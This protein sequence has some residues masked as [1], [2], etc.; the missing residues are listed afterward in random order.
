MVLL[1]GV[2]SSLPDCT[3]DSDGLCTSCDANFYLNDGVCT[4]NCPSHCTESGSTCDCSSSDKTVFDLKFYDIT[5]LQQA[6]VE[7]FFPKMP[8]DSDE[9]QAPSLTK[10]RGFYFRYHSEM[11]CT[12]SCD[13][14]YDL[15]HVLVFWTK[16]YLG[17]SCD[18]IKQKDDFV[19]ARLHTGAMWS[20]ADWHFETKLTKTSDGTFQTGQVQVNQILETWNK[21]AFKTE[22]LKATD[23]GG[24][25]CSGSSCHKYNLV[26]LSSYKD[27]ALQN[28]QSYQDVWARDEVDTTGGNA[29]Y[30]SEGDFQG[31]VYRIILRN[32]RSMSESHP[33]IS[34]CDPGFY[35]DENSQ[36]QDCYCSDKVWCVRGTGCD[37]CYSE[38]CDSCHGFTEPEC[39]SCSDGSL[40]PCS[41]CDYLCDSCQTPP[42]ECDTNL[43][44]STEEINN[45]CLKN[46]PYGFGSPCSFTSGVVLEE[47]F[48]TFSFT[49]FQ[50]GTGPS[51]YFPFNNGE[52]DDVLPMKQRGVYADSS[53]MIRSIDEANLYHDFTLTFWLK[54]KTAGN[55]ITKGVDLVI[56]PSASMTLKLENKGGMKQDGTLTFSASLNQW[57]YSAFTCEFSSSSGTTMKRYLDGNSSPAQTSVAD[58]IFRHGTGNHIQIGGSVSSGFIYRVRIL[59]EVD[60]VIIGNDQICSGPFTTECLWSC[61]EDEYSDGTNCQ[62]CNFCSYGCVRTEDC[63]PCDDRLCKECSDFGS[64]CLT[65]KDNAEDSSGTCACMPGYFLDSNYQCSPCPSNCDV[66]SNSN[67]NQC[68]VCSP[69]YFLVNE[70]CYPYCPS[71]Y[72]PNSGVCDLS[73]DFVFQLQPHYIQDVVT[74]SKSSIPFSTGPDT[75]FY[76]DFAQGDPYPA[77]GRGYFFNGTSHMEYRCGT[78]CSPTLVISPEFTLSMWVKP[79]SS[80]GTLFSKQKNTAP[81]TKSVSLELDS[82]YLRLN[83]DIPGYT[84]ST[85]SCVL[86]EDW[87]F[88]A[89]STSIDSTPEFRAFIQV[90]TTC[91]DFLSIGP[92]FLE[93]FQDNY[94]LVI[95][96]A[97]RGANTFTDFFSGFIWEVK[98]YSTQK[99]TYSLV[100]SSGCKTCTHC[101]IDNSDECLPVC[102]ITDYWNSTD[103]DSCNFECGKGCVNDQSCNLCADQLCRVCSDFET[104]TCSECV[105]NAKGSPCECQ[106]GYFAEVSWC[107]ECHSSCKTCDGP[108]NNNCTSCDNLYLNSDGTC[109]AC[110]DSTYLSQNTCENC[111]QLCTTCTNQSSCLT[112][113][114]N[115]ALNSNN[116]CDCEAKFKQV[117]SV[118]VE[119]YFHASIEVSENNKLTLSF[120]E[121]L[122]TNLSTSDYRVL[123]EDLNFTV[124]MERRNKRTLMIDL[125]TEQKI[126]QDEPFTLEFYNSTAIVSANKKVLY[127]DFLKGNL[128]EYDPYF[129]DVQKGVRIS[130]GITTVAL[131]IVLSCA[132]LS[133]SFPALWSMINTLQILSYIPIAAYYLDPMLYGIFKA[134]DDILLVP[135]VFEYF[136]DPS[137]PRNQH[138]SSYDYGFE[139]SYLFLNAGKYF[140]ILSGLL[141][142]LPFI[143]MLSECKNEKIQKVFSK[144]LKEY[145]YGILVRLWFLAFLR[146]SISCFIQFWNLPGF[147]YLG[148]LS[149]F[150]S[151]AFTVIILVTPLCVFRF[152]KNNRDQI[153][154]KE[155]RTYEVWGSVFYEFKLDTDSYAKYFYSFFTMRRIL[156]V[157]SITTLNEFKAIQAVLNILIMVLYWVFLVVVRPYS[158]LI[159]QIANWVSEGFVCLI[160]I[161]MPILY[162]DPSDVIIYTTENLVL[163]SA[164]LAIFTQV[165]A[166]VAILVKNIVKLIKEHKERKTHDQT[167]SI[168]EIPS[169]QEISS[170]QSF[171]QGHRGP[172]I[173][174]ISS[175]REISS[176]K[177]V[178]GEYR[179]PRLFFRR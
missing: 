55:L 173:V 138:Q 13:Y 76:P 125:L 45:I 20:D 47:T 73:D 38:L 8:F 130:E 119:N 46:C 171:D 40:P 52:N 121:D 156:Y 68:S 67:F 157:V 25:P 43:C 80:S 153:S 141:V 167:S 75:S 86:N 100:Q 160:F 79:T 105:L 30:I 175:S 118:C 65:C 124:G 170:D 97:L 164:T 37:F 152:S 16:V 82:N 166:S 53:R 123:I 15:N 178:H 36:C 112:C 81:Y 23:S 84:G 2:A 18:F 111:P 133:Y 77:K 64:G 60:T 149:Y 107:K 169:S 179:D 48:S 92:E 19:K 71:G 59:Q 9:L 102:G 41:N 106:E 134:M 98:L 70:V 161:I 83:L 35:V 1:L 58:Y 172:S 136:L 147:E 168:V 95:G 90:N 50:S 54:L 91:S 31:F 114:E 132:I 56:D 150:L 162:F 89:V 115:A 6:S 87:N 27:E 146:M 117:S 128:N 131:G 28:Q 39:D 33:S 113:V 127:E 151:V 139:S 148:V 74:D 144:A 177:A 120:T 85:S 3:S 32:D 154:E 14:F 51:T 66:C 42:W 24:N 93:D 104:W 174:E 116:L 17:N 5:N 135:N 137:S 12:S 126:P 159:L 49:H 44:N 22:R 10:E 4:K 129:E 109:Q 26:N 103:C 69:G 34:D 29:W 101:P 96:A 176:G 61:A 163:C 88:V 72:S 7:N 108:N 62:P 122:Q 99:D 110:P 11:S 145:K 165:V 158:E 63:N 94:Y 78:N 142:L 57:H 21:I 155:E 140:T 143:W